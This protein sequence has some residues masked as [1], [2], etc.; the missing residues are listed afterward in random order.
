VVPVQPAPMS[1]STIK[2]EI[3]YFIGSW[4]CLLKC[5]IGCF[6]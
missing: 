6:Y 2:S 3:A 5:S 1:A 4:L